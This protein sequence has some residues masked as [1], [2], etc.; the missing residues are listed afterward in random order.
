M[1]GSVVAALLSTSKMNQLGPLALPIGD[2]PA[3]LQGPDC[4]LAHRRAAF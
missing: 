4:E 2:Q 1:G 3:V